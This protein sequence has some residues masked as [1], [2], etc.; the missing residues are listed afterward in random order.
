MGASPGGGFS[1]AGGPAH[2]GADLGDLLGNLFGRGEASW[3]GAGPFSQGPQRGIDL[4]ADLHLS[5]N[6]A[7]HGVTTS[8][9]IVSDASCPDCHGNGAAPGTTPRVCSACSGRGVL[10]DN[11]GFFSFSRPCQNC[12]GRGSF[13]DTPC[14]TCGGQGS[15][16]RPR[17][18]K[19]RLPQAVKDGQQIR[20]KGKGGPGRSGG[21][22]GDLYVRVHV[23]PHPLFR[24]DGTHFA[25]SVPITYVE[26]ALGA[27]IRVPTFDGEAVTI[28]IPPGTRSGRTFRVRGKGVAVGSNQG[29]LMVTVDLVVP[30][31]VNDAE[32][33]A[34]EALRDAAETSPRDVLGV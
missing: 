13:I 31:S 27:D 5:F 18:V 23:E 15:V 29:D 17:I 19:V 11:Q 14:P 10:D 33:A 12:Q 1:R 8:V 16:T 20:L 28:R 34:L 2:G 32:R 4:E 26:A 21:P 25:L 24:R 6:D 7:I 30:S 9:N 3:G 22:S